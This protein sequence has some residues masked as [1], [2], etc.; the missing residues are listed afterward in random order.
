VRGEGRGR[1]GRRG[2]GGVVEGVWEVNFSQ[3]I[4]MWTCFYHISEVFDVWMRRGE[5]CG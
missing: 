1:I 4:S 5:S 2:G 3:D